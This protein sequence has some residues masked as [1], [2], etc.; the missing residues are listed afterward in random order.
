M[1]EGGLVVAW[2]WGVAGGGRRDYNGVGGNK[3]DA[4]KRD[5]GY[6]YYLDCG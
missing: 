5:D 4:P 6:V 1:I 2:E 3:K